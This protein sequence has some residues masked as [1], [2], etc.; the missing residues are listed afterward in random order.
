MSAQTL[1]RLVG[2]AP[3]C[4]DR[5]QRV[6][7]VALYLF[8]LGYPFHQYYVFGMA[9][10]QW[11]LLLFTGVAMFIIGLKFVA[12]AP[13]KVCQAISRLTDRR[14][15]KFEVISQ[16]EFCTLLFTRADNWARIIGILTA[17][18]MLIAFIVSLSISFTWS[19]V[20]LAFGEVL[21]AYIAGNYLGRMIGFGYLGSELEKAGI[22]IECDPVHVDGVGGFKPIGDLY[23]YQ[24]M[25]AGIPA[26]FLATWWFI[27]PLWPRDYSHWENAYFM[28]LIIAIIIEIFA[29]V[30][31]LI[32][33]HRIMSASKA[34]WLKRADEIGN[35][36]QEMKHALESAQT[37]G[38]SKVKADQIEELT[39]SYWVIEN[40][41]T[42][43]VDIKTRR[44]FELHNILLFVP[45][46]GDIAKHNINWEKI[47]VALKPLIS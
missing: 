2:F 11:D 37:D 36:I 41:P 33:F 34:R 28:L 4:G 14:I 10:L 46:V 43:P 6:T 27:F 39:K 35:Q 32:S 42:W 9:F 8:L 38:S 7:I 24:A 17:V 16:K 23:F 44:R 30:A 3:V 18:A 40:M 12:A 5:C 1:E 45:V 31:P 13:Q 20:V 25:V 22:S 47:V 21:G 26:I 15:L 29:F 19:R